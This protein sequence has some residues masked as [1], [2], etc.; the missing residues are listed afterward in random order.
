MERLTYGEFITNKIA[1]IPYGQAFQTDVIA[2][3]MAEEYAIPSHKA[4]H[5]P[6]PH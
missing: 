1:D 5:L 6:M 4:K 2:E 3:A